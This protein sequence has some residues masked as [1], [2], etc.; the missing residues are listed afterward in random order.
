MCEP[1]LF[2]YTDNNF[3]GVVFRPAT[4]CGYAPRQRLDLS[5]NILTNLAIRNNEITVFG[6]EQLRP[7]LHVQDYAELC[8]I[9]ITC[10]D[11]LISN[12]IFNCGYENK[13]IMEIAK[14]VKKV[15]EEK[16]D[17]KK[18]ISLKVTHS[19]DKR[20]YH[21]NSDKIKNKLGF[22][23]KRS[24]ANAVDG[25]FNAFFTIYYLTV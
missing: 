13:S 20:S 2:D 7:N 19:D 21:I 12:E 5:V 17:Y 6:G 22:V 16:T 8:N 4:V 10:D 18:V 3:I 14:D 23:P 1:I 9:L 11:N 25:L 15:V 24:I